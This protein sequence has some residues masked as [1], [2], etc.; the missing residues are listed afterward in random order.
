MN[1]AADIEATSARLSK[2]NLERFDRA[3]IRERFK[4]EHARRSMAQ[5][6]RNDGREQRK[7][8]TQ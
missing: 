5:R 7:W 2:E 1:L 4:W 8:K 6:L 3:M